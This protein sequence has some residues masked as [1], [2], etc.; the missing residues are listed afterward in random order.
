LSQ[1]VYRYVLVGVSEKE[2]QKKSD[3]KPVEAS[4]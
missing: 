2:L 4:A 3:R 1:P